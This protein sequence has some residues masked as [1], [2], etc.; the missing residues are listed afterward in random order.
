MIPR[1]RSL[2]KILVPIALLLPALVI[3]PGC[4][5]S[6]QA[7]IDSLN[8]TNSRMRYER[9]SVMSANKRLM[10]QVEALASE[11][12]V[13]SARAADLEVQLRE[14]D[15]APTMAAAPTMSSDPGSAYAEALAQYRKLDFSGALKSFEGLLQKGVRDDLADNCHYWIGECLYGMGKYSDAVHHFETTLGYASS[16][17]KDDS[18]LMIANCHAAMGNKG[19]AK[20]WYNKMITSYPAS[21]YLKRAQEKLNA[22][23]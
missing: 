7:E 4:G 15:A 10:Q 16:E 3:G 6:Q 9:D 23:G 20:D 22:L 21:P 19:A 12:R 18:M 17:K 14:K 5:S 2:T 1:S 11:N 8:E 13:Q